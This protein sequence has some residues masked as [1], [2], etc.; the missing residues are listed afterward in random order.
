MLAFVL[1]A[2]YI[3]LMRK[4]LDISLTVIMTLTLSIAMLWPMDQPLLAPEGSD[5]LIHLIAFAVL[6]LPLAYTCRFGLVPIFIGAITFGGAVE[7]IQ[8]SFNRMADINDWI[9]DIAGTVFGIFCG[10]LWR[11]M[12]KV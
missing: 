11:L 12:H 6:C 8:P 4:Y 10:W 2:R 5:K 7:L 3:V 1:G 9:A